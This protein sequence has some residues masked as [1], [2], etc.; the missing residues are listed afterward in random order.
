MTEWDENFATGTTAMARRDVGNRWGD[1]LPS[2][3]HCTSGRVERNGDARNGLGRAG[4]PVTAD[5]S[6]VAAEVAAA[7]DHS[8]AAAV[9]AAGIRRVLGAS[10]GVVVA[11]RAGGGWEVEAADPTAVAPERD[12]VDALVERFDDGSRLVRWAAGESGH[13]LAAGV[14][15]R[16]DEVAGT[17][18]L[19]LALGV[20]AMSAQSESDARTL[21]AVG[22]LGLR[23]VSAKSAR[24]SEDRLVEAGM[25]LSAELHLDDVLNRLVATAR[26]VLDARYA[27]LG[28]LDAERTTLANFVTSGID[29]AEREAIG[30]IPTGRGL[31]GLLISDSRPVRVDSIRD[32]PR[33]S[34][35]PPNHPSM[36]T[37]L[38]VPIRVGTDVFGNLY[39]TDKIG[40]PFTAAD[41]LVALTLAAQ[42]AVAIG[43]AQRYGEKER[44]VL[45]AARARERAAEDGLRRAIE[46]QEA[47]RARIAR[48][49]HDEA[50]QELTALALH[51]RA[52]DD[53]VTS[54]EGIAR[55]D[56]VRQALAQTSTNLRELAVELRPSGLREHGL[57]SA[58]QRQAA[59]LHETSGILVDVA[60]GAIPSDLPEAVEIGLFRVVQEALTN[61]VRHSGAANASVIANRRGG[62]LRVVVEDDGRGFDPSAPSER[63]GLA[64]IRERVVLLGGSLRIDSDIDGGTTVI[65]ELEV[66]GG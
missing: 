30:D 47:E 20:D 25:V 15:V 45:I 66:A 32:D 26:E 7:T 63:L 17:A 3:H 14:G 9:L 64:G 43:N 24:P 33:A 31:L 11:N 2:A 18:R 59:R 40:G 41:E 51:L 60:V 57:A 62:R 37:F 21:A 52:L 8:A 46:A 50:G 38:G 27:A 34:G 6:T 5:L 55:L 58:I 10:T 35:F 12:Q 39:V 36:T 48:E 28:V 4:G 29:D 56:V 16:L 42:A 53:E 54:P 65:V 1:R 13:D 49:L 44:A 22:S 19:L 61:V 23:L